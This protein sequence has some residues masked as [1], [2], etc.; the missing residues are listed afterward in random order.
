MRQ[1]V[2]YAIYEY[3]IELHQQF[4]DAV[5]FNRTV[6]VE[7]AVK[8]NHDVTPREVVLHSDSLDIT[9]LV[10]HDE[11]IREHVRRALPVAI[12]GDHLRP[13]AS[14]ADTDLVLQEDPQLDIRFY[15][16]RRDHTSTIYLC[17][18]S[19]FSVCSIF[20]LK[21]SLKPEKKS[22]VQSTS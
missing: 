18:S 8:A 10:D 1:R 22:C 4:L 13:A 16:G 9:V 15:G 7:L 19:T 17:F 6:I 21:R 12:D 5:L 11:I 14:Q 20:E 2:F 3:I